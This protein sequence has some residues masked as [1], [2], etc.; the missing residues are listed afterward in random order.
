MGFDFMSDR[1]PRVSRM[2]TYQTSPGRF[3]H[4]AATSSD[5]M[6]H[7]KPRTPLVADFKRTAHVWA[8][9]VIATTAVVHVEPRTRAI[10]RAVV[11][12]VSGLRLGWRGEQA[13]IVS[14]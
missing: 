9:L 5:L 14:V 13:V 6:Q 3:W 4:H 7:S 2:P 11:R 10:D 12:Q 1:V 8:K